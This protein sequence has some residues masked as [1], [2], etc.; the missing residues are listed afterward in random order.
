MLEGNLSSDDKWLKKYFRTVNLEQWGD[1]SVKSA[2]LVPQIS[3]GNIYD[4]KLHLRH[5]VEGSAEFHDEISFFQLK[6]AINDAQSS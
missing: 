3:N 6:N 4:L 2:W 5:Q 1:E